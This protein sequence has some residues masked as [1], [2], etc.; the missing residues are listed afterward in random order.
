MGNHE[1]LPI[2]RNA[3]NI[4]YCQIHHRMGQ[5]INKTV[6]LQMTKQPKLSRFNNP[7]P[8]NYF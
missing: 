1:L 5:M 8:Q 7:T 2:F 3:E 4:I 6:P